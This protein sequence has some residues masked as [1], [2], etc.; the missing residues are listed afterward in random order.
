MAA[1]TGTLDGNP[2]EQAVTW[3]TDGGTRTTVTWPWGFSA[4]FNP[5]LELLDPTGM[6]V[7]RAGDVIS[8]AGSWITG[9]FSACQINGTLYTGEP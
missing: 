1:L 8:L 3:I 2:Y 7:A 6:V 9:G 5:R 4:R